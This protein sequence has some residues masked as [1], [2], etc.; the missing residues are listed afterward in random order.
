MRDHEDTV[1]VRLTAA[2]GA[3]QISSAHWPAIWHRLVHL[4][5]ARSAR[6]E[7]DPP[8]VIVA[9]AYG[10]A[11]IAPGLLAEIEQL[12]GT[13]LHVE[14]PGHA[15][16]AD[17]P[18]P[19]EA[20]VLDSPAL[21]RLED[22]ARRLELNQRLPGDWLDAHLDPG[23]THYLRAGLWHRLS[24]RA[25]IGPHLRCELLIQV[26]DGEQVL[27]LLDVPPAEYKALRSVQTRSDYERMDQL[28][29]TAR[30][31]REYEENTR[32]W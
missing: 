27:S 16:A 12:A 32:R 26:Q 9:E 11:E 31:V 7:G 28:M 29:T 3:P 20:K 21:L 14:M 15:S 5:P 17:P 25:D 6:L 10:S 2:P 1:T 19:H 30:S 8:R 22:T 24:H 4:Q 13:L 23:G 18:V